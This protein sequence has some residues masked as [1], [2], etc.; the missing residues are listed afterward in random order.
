VV[1]ADSPSILTHEF[2]H[3]YTALWLSWLYLPAYGL[4]YA[5]F[6][7]DGSPHERLTRRFERD[8]RQRWGRVA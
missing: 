3:A 6:G 5:I 7:H 4:E 1:F 8:C 2:C